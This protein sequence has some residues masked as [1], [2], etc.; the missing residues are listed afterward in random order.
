[1]N[2]E[3][4]TQL[5]AHEIGTHVARRVNGERS[6]FKLLG[7]GLDRYESS[8]EGIATMREQSIVNEPIKDFSGLAGY[9][10]IGLAL[11][12]DGRPRDFRETYDILEKYY[13]YKKLHD[14]QK[15]TKEQALEKAQTIAWNRCVRTF[16]GTDCKTKGVCSTKDLIYRDGNIDA[17]NAI[18]KNPDEIMKF[19]IGKY[20]PSNPRHLW[21]LSNL[22]ITDQD[23][24]DLEK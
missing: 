9:L 21:I 13:T 20:D 8:D 18:G 22:G 4:L 11:G 23:L 7:L 2:V 24:A 19:N 16:R 15:I 5:I 6:S 14:G 10:A 17:W 1:M 12:T 3:E